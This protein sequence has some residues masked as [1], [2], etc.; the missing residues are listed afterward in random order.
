MLCQL[1][2]HDHKRTGC[3]VCNSFSKY[4][5]QSSVSGNCQVICG[6][7]GSST[8]LLSAA[9]W[10]KVCSKENVFAGYRLLK[11]LADRLQRDADDREVAQQFEIHDTGELPPSMRVMDPRKEA[12][13]R[14]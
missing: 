11:A 6:L 1:T 3:T 10:V 12:K 7:Y 13:E 4:H 5:H 2:G 14:L 9:G 8:G